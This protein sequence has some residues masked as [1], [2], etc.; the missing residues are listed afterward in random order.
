TRRGRSKCRRH[1]VC[2]ATTS[3][4]CNSAGCGAA[5]CFQSGRLWRRRYVTYGAPPRAC[6]APRLGT[7]A[8]V[9]NRSSLSPTSILARAVKFLGSL[10]LGA[11]ILLYLFGLVLAG[12]LYQTGAGIY[13]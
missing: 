12:T 5:V 4:A 7:G 8:C 9:P 6:S 2:R 1:G 10:E 3:R 11:V 13:L